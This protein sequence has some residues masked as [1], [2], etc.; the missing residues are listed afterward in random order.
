MRE[1]APLNIILKP[2]YIKLGAPPPLRYL[3][4]NRLNTT[5]CVTRRQNPTSPLGGGGLGRFLFQL[6]SFSNPL[7]PL[8]GGVYPSPYPLPWTWTG[9]AAGRW[10]AQDG[11]RWL[12]EGLREPKMASK[13][14]QDSPTWLKIAHNMP[15]RGSKT[16]LRRLQMV[17]KLPKDA[18]E[19]PTSFKNLRKINVFCLQKKGGFF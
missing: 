10:S 7:L 6:D 9:G 3:R 12:Q 19:R 14:A 5:T 8:R 4:R 11:P 18:P 2:K 15:P 16:T 1:F 13:I 17:K